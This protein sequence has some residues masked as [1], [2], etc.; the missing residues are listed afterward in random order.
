M[1][2]VLETDAFF[3]NNARIQTCFIWALDNLLTGLRNN[4]IPD[5]FFPEVSIDIPPYTMS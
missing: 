1:H 2:L 5:I 4:L 3:W